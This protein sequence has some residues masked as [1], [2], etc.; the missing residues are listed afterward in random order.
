MRHLLV[1]TL[2]VLLMGLAVP[3]AAQGQDQPAQTASPASIQ[4]DLDAVEEEDDGDWGISSFLASQA[5]AERASCGTESDLLA[6]QSTSRPRY[7][8]NGALI[9]EAP[10]AACVPPGS[11]YGEDATALRAQEQ[12]RAGGDTPQAL[13]NQPDCVET[14]SGYTCASAGSSGRATYERQQ[15]CEETGT[16]RNCSSSFSIGTSEGARNAAQE[17]IDRLR[18]D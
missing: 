11:R 18:E 3:A 15:Q 16:T 8:Q 12:R 7:D 17:A 6:V 10:S 1:T 5:A 2:S 9:R 14:A 4:F 13:L